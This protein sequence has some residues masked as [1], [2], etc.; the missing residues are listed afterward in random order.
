MKS[1][2]RN[3]MDVLKESIS[4]RHARMEELPYV[5]ALM[6]RQL[7][8]QSYVAQL[9]AM[10]VIHEALEDSLRQVH[11]CA[12]ASL[13]LSRPSRLAL[14]R[15]DLEPFES[16]YLPDCLEAI[17]EARIIAQ[18]ISRY[19]LGEPESLLGI[20]YVLEGMTLGNSVHLSD[21]VAT[22]G[23]RVSGSTSYYC[24]YGGRTGDC[25][26]EFSSI[27]NAIPL[28]EECVACVIDAACRFVDH[29]ERLFASLYP[30]SDHGWGFRAS[31]LNPE[32]G[33]HAMPDNPLE[34]EAAISAAYRC[35]E[36]YP[37]FEE[38]YRERGRDF[39]KSDAA[40]L[41][42]LAELPGPQLMGQVE[43]L[44]RLLANRGMPRITLERQLELLHQ[45]LTAAVPERRQQYHG[46]LD[47]A[48][49]LK[50]ERLRRIPEDSF[51]KLA[52]DFH[53]ATDGEMKGKLDRTGE[54]IVSAICDEAA[55][56]AEAA[57]SLLS[58]LTDKQLF[59]SIWTREVLKTAETARAIVREQHGKTET[60]NRR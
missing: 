1:R 29:L 20:L 60:G 57:T 6:G 37:Y 28:N 2:S 53:E 16:Q 32:A 13:L 52:H 56:I 4:G 36:E 3:L 8:L 15:S 39:G 11:G 54:L 48:G 59:S 42:T 43:W 33:N 45:E 35:R 44:G 24:G 46:L 40:W 47:A 41:V 31:M 50:A 22:F 38:R 25:W 21:V 7:P 55:G 14:L 49:K 23:A 34:I 30:I 10:A 27:M 17:E 58:W 26:R 12:V 18:L 19:R 5:K 51:I 9:R